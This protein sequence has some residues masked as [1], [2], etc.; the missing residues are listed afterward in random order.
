MSKNHDISSSED[1]KN[2][3]YYDFHGGYISYDPLQFTE[4]YT[5]KSFGGKIKNSQVTESKWH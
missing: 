2:H 4:H 1:N 3:G 5:V